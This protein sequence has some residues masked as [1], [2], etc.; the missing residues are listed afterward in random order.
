MSLS[1]LISGNVLNGL[2][3]F[4]RTLMTDFFLNWRFLATIF[5]PWTSFGSRST[6]SI[7]VSWCRYASKYKSKLPRKEDWNY[8]IHFFWAQNVKRW[9][10]YDLIDLGTSF[11]TWN[12][13]KFWQSESWVIRDLIKVRLSSQTNFLNINFYKICDY[14]VV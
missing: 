5:K 13:Y 1:V 12:L 10:W 9:K 14:W 7:Y 8:S 2:N 6:T 4:D 11:P 3:V